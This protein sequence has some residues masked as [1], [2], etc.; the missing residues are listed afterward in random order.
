MTDWN[1]LPGV[2]KR[3]LCFIYLTGA[4]AAAVSLVVYL[5]AGDCILLALG[6]ILLLCCIL[7]GKNEWTAL[8]TGN[9]ETVEGVCTG[10]APLPFRHCRKIHLLNEDGTE[11]TL[12]LDRNARIQI[13]APYRFY[14]Q[15]STHPP[16]G[17]TYLDAPLSTGSFLG[18]EELQAEEFPASGTVEK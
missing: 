4:V 17:N 11:I 13:G 7:H 2:L 15:K 14:F 1:Q 6:G 12:L 8:S 3:R 9:Y 16:I 18:C 10:I 5:S